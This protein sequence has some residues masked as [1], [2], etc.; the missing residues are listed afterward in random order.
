MQIKK[1]KQ[2]LSED[3]PLFNTARYNIPVT[4]NNM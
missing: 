3:F 1:K 4:N 2:S